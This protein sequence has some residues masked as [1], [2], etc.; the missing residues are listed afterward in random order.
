[1]R[2]GGGNIYIMNSAKVEMTDGIIRNGKATNGS[3]ANVLIRIGTF[4]MSGG[5]IT[6]ELTGLT[7]EF[8]GNVATTDTGAKF[9]MNGGTVSGGVA[10]RGGG[11]LAIVMNGGTIEIGGDAVVT[12]GSSKQGGNIY[13]NANHAVDIKGAAAPV[14]K[15]SGGTISDGTAAEKGGNVYLGS[16]TGFHPTVPATMTMTGGTIT[17]G[18]INVSSVSGGGV[19]VEDGAVLTVSGEVVIHGNTAKA[20]DH[21][22]TKSDVCF[23]TKTNYLRIAE[24]GLSGNAMIGLRGQDRGLQYTSSGAHVTADI[25]QHL[26]YFSPRHQLYF[27]TEKGYVSLRA[28]Q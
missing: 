10:N 25:L 24:P 12:G 23:T 8:G 15:I 20:N 14:L 21:G 17:G 9:V 18:H 13:A 3:G 6:N 27:D 4:T 1:M 22:E 2:H 7:C 26:D 19:C 11:N 16:G 5:S 28:P